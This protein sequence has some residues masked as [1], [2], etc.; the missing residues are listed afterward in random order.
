MQPQQQQPY[1]PPPPHLLPL[2]EEWG[3]ILGLS[4][5]YSKPFGEL[6]QGQQKLAVI[7]RA[8]IGAPPL[9][10]FDEA[11]QGLDSQHRRLVLSLLESIAQAASSWLTVLYVS[12]HEDEALAKVTTHV[13]ELEKGRVA[14]V[15]SDNEWEKV[16]EGRRKER[17]AR[18][19]DG[20]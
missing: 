5:L 19:G 9:L 1:H 10:I 15:G 8:L 6:S 7:A 18:G 16:E 14:F 13:L 2:L 11:C 3:Q 20:E 4:S 12:H 17:E